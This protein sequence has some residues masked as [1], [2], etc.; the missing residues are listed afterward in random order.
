MA[1][2][3]SG[4]RD[5]I[6]VVDDSRMMRHVVVAL[7]H[8][9][10]YSTVLEA[11]TITEAELIL[12]AGSVALV[13]SDWHMP[14]GSGL[15][16]LHFVRQTPTIAATPFIMVTTDNQRESVLEAA[17]TGVQ[18]FMCKPLDKDLLFEK[19]TALSKKYGFAEPRRPGAR[20][21]VGSVPQG[22]ADAVRELGAGMDLALGF[23]VTDHES[24][25]SL[26]GDHPCVVE[27]KKVF[28]NSRFVKI[29]DEQVDKTYSISISAWE[30]ELKRRADKAASEQK[31]D[32][33]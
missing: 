14:G 28:P 17:K 31:K 22:A 32:P 23:K 26:A 3:H 13:L 24:I 2:Q 20:L 30:R 1:D 16:L 6:L 21:P 4:S 18:A 11:A 33:A 19:L 8:E 9:F 5:G 25:I 15:D 29:T 27:L 7:L 10:G 12:K